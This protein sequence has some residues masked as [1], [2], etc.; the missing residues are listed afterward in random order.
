MYEYMHHMYVCMFVRLYAYHRCRSQSQKFQSFFFVWFSFCLGWTFKGQRRCSP[1]IVLSFKGSI[2]CPRCCLPANSNSKVSP[3]VCSTNECFF[4][5][6]TLTRIGDLW[7]HW[8]AW[9][10]SSLWFRFEL[11]YVGLFME[12]RVTVAEA[13]TFFL[14]ALSLSHSKLYR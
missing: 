9:K 13:C 12:F 10:V 6:H 14:T 5:P 11:C 7:F 2:P 8:R 1:G 3:N 4:F